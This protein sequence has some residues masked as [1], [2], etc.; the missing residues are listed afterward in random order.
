MKRTAVLIS[1][2]LAILHFDLFPQSLGTG[3][4]YHTMLL[5]SDGTVYTCGYNYY[6]ELGKGSAGDSH[7]PV[8]VVKGLYSGSLSLGD[9]PGNPIIAISAGKYTSIALAQDGTVFTWGRNSEGQ[10][11]NNSKVNIDSPVKVSKG[12]YSGTTYLGDNPTNKIIH[13]STGEDCSI[14]LASDGIVYTWGKGGDGQLGNGT[15]T[16]NLTPIKVI[17]GE[18]PGTTYLGDDPNNKII[19]VSAGYGYSLAIDENG[20]VYTWGNNSYGQLGNNSTV[21]S[22]IPVKVNKGDYQGTAYLGDDPNNKIIKA[23]AGDGHCIAVAQD[24]IVYTWGNN[25]KGQLGNESNVNSLIPVKVRMGEY[26]GT[27]FLGDNSSNKIT[28]VAI[29]NSH[30]LAIDQQGKVYAWGL[31]SEGQL[32]NN[33]KDNKNVPIKTLKGTYSGNT[34]L[35]DNADNKIIAIATGFTHSIALANNGTVYGWGFNTNGQL[36]DNTMT[37]KSSPVVV[38]VPGGPLPVQLV[39]FTAKYSGKFVNLNWQTATEVNN[40][41]FEI[42]R[43]SGGDQL[44]LGIWKKI[45]FVK[46]NGNSNSY[47]NYS[48][49][50]DNSILGKIR[51]RLKQ[52][53]NDGKFEYSNEVEVNTIPI[54]NDI[55]L[56]Q[57]YPN[58]FNPSTQIQFAVIKNT[59]AVLTIYNILGE[60]IAVL[61]NGNA[62][63]G[64]VYNVTFVGEKL[65][66]GIYYYKLQTNEGTEVKKMLLKK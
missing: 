11:G 36:G 18:Y 6:G 59:H 57:N 55:L 19:S 16:S 8:K 43:Q 7:I 45:G 37:Q 5:K 47:K 50:D 54:Q 62:A 1:L 40:Y 32:G 39:T 21:A 63:A 2:M 31:N 48:F 51:Y 4:G 34:F 24:G 14:A 12:A 33:T 42:E 60:K 3:L 35:G 52:V 56:N 58:P 26:A 65:T 30:S 22:N 20:F 49:S 53:D 44:A 15:T 25:S 23:I 27:A 46:G 29:G 28:D 61:F 17:K 41:G 38:Q 13:V 64:Q 10:L 66:S 9:N